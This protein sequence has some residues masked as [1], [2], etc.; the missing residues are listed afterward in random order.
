MNSN[1]H[2]LVTFPDGATKKFQQNTT[3]Y[4][5]A[6]SVATG[7]A[8]S[9]YVAKINNE[10]TDLHR[11]IS[12]SCD[13]QI[14][15]RAEEEALSVIRHDCTHILAQAVQE[16]F[17]NVILAFGP[18]IENGFY[19]DFLSEHA[20]CIEDFPKIE[21]RMHEIVDRNLLFEREVWEYKKAI[22]H[23]TKTGEV[24]KVEH[25]KELGERIE[26][27]IYKQGDW[28][29]LCL[30][31]HGT[32]T[33]GVG[34]AFALTKLSGAYWKGRKDQS[35]L[36]RIYGTCWATTNDLESYKNRVKEAEERDHRKIGKVMQLFH[37]QE[38]AAGSVFWHE[39]GWQLYRNLM[40]YL[41][42]R[43]KVD[44]YAEVNTPQLVDRILWEQ[45][46]HWD[47]FRENMYI[48]D[49]EDDNRTFALKPMNCPCHVQIFKRNTVSYRDLPI[50]MAEF[51]S[52][53][54][55]EPSGALHG[56]MR[57]RAFT[58]DDGHIFCTEEQIESETILFCKQLSRVYK[59]LGFDKFEIKLSTRPK[60]RV[61]ND[62]TW[63]K[64]EGAL[65]QAIKSAGFKYSINKGEGAFYGP[66]LDFILRDAIGRDW[67]CGTLQVDF[68]LPSRLDAHY[69]DSSGE[70]VRPVMLHRAILGS[71]ERFIGILIEH[72]S[73]RFPLWLAPTQ[74]VLASITEVANDYTNKIL[75]KLHEQGVMA[76]ADIKN[77]KI[78]YKIR[79]HSAKKVPYIWI[80]GRKEMDDNKVNIR[81]LG[82]QETYSIDY[83]KA[84][85]QLTEESKAPDLR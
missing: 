16:L 17:P 19:Y 42:R 32:S 74:V 65:E 66:K 31:P 14:I 30:G 18:T 83:E 25:I 34:H 68:V 47:K 70:K 54:R 2:I 7:L 13:L 64:S 75:T 36:Q 43:L 10:L 72:Y 37:L 63:D 5:V 48:V 40:S 3:S 52:C 22:N 23:F 26:L 9:A 1:N 81:K 53:I 78:G 80:I 51:G 69:I 77:E 73:G 6:K 45:S 24:L 41:Q 39:K 12:K 71:F 27:S 79:Y 29:D 46:G 44:G 38:E 61:G 57:V 60:L 59:D 58:Q 56:I 21:K 84:I 49:A 28:L 15:K 55:K 33:K 35:V 82:S 50:R 67:Q 20:F 85:S 8:K 11:T 76:V 4:E 62:A